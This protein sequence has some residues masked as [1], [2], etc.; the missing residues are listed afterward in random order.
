MVVIL[1]VRDLFIYSFQNPSESGFA[2]PIFVP[3]G[4]Q[5]SP[6]R[7]TGPAARPAHSSAHLIDADLDAAL[8]SLF[9]LGRR[10]PA[11][12]LVS[13]QWRD[14]GPEPLGIG[15]GFDSH[16]KVCRQFVDRAARYL[17][18]GHASNYACLAS[19]VKPRHLEILYGPLHS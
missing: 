3:L 16:L 6:V 11:D 4:E 7:A 8:S 14:I 18:S 1:R 13:C 10:N 19:T 2:I 12:P 15:V 17:L 9:F 5:A